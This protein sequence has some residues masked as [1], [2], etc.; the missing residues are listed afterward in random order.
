VFPKDHEETDCVR[1]DEAADK[2]FHKL[3]RVHQV[4]ANRRG[5]DSPVK[6]AIL[7]T[8]LCL[9]HPE[10]K[11]Y[12]EMG[13]IRKTRCRAFP[14]SLDPCADKNG[15]GT[16]VTSVLLRTA[17]DIELYIAR[18]ADDAGNIIDDE[19]YQGVINVHSFLHEAKS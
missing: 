8:G 12:I 16:H 19:D 15:H 10:F 11:T 3:R 7:D 17:P 18:V 2:W 9:Q 1:D 6:V 5:T 14:E 4:F 13:T